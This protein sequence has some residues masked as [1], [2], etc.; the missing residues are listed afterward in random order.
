MSASLL[1]RSK[2]EALDI[3]NPQQV[4]ILGVDRNILA[5]DITARV[6]LS[7]W[8]KRNEVKMKWCSRS[9]P[10]PM[11]QLMLQLTLQP[12]LRQTLQPTPLAM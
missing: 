10:L 9:T 8:L 2:K 7:W 3:V 4:L 6:P 1:P 11:L 5:N 12:M